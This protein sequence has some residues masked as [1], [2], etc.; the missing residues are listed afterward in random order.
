M[1]FFSFRYRSGINPSTPIKLVTSDDRISFEKSN[2]VLKF[3]NV[4]PNDTG[5]YQCRVVAKNHE[6]AVDIQPVAMQSVK[7]IGKKILRYNFRS[8]NLIL[9]ICKLKKMFSSVLPYV[10]DAHKDITVIEENPIDLTCTVF[11]TVNVTVTWTVNTTEGEIAFFATR[12]FFLK[13][14]FV[15]TLLLPCVP[16]QHTS[17]LLNGPCVS[18]WHT[19]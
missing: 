7:V 4:N 13:R 18:I 6:S 19:L 1:L 10:K 3:T 14:T 9:R 11:S 16:I 8:F 2:E 17:V 5:D 15:L 12:V